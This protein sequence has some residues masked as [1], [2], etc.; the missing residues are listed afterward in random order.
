ML[1]TQ[2]RIVFLDYLRVAVPFVAWAAA[3]I[4]A[5]GR[6]WGPLLFNFPDEGGHLWFVPMLLGLYLLMPLLSPEGEARNNSRAIMS[7]FKELCGGATICRELK[8]IGT[9]K[10]LCSCENCVRNAV[11]A[12]A[13]TLEI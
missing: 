2:N 1:A 6:K 13:E 3:Y 5:A 11:H 4:A 7:R 8:G 12:A 10:V 9:G